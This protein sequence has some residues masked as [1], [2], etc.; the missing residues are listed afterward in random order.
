M[1]QSV[2]YN[3]PATTF[4]RIND[5]VEQLSH[6]M[7]EINEVRD[8]IK[9]NESA[10]RIDEELVDL[11]HSLETLFRIYQRELGDEYVED[12]F[13]QIEDK[14]RERGYYAQGVCEG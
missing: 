12:L 11:F 9:N 4:A 2:S 1:S 6:V 5:Q 7:S 10:E 3:F 14:N 13:A 8:A